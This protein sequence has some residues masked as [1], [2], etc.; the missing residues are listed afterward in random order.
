MLSLVEQR[1]ITVLL[2]SD[3]TIETHLT[4]TLKQTPDEFF[5]NL[6]KVTAFVKHHILHGYITKQKFKR[7]VDTPLMS[8]L[9][10]QTVKLKKLSDGDDGQ[11]GGEGDEKKKKKAKQNKKSSPV[12]SIQSAQIKKVDWRIE[13]GLIHVIDQAFIPK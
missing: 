2:P 11:S 13:N 6:E 5:S 8:Y 1:N 7:F 12:Y 4:T 3:E 9:D 10:G